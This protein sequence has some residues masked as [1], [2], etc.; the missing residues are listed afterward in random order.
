MKSKVCILIALTLLCIS[1]AMVNRASARASDSTRRELVES[2]Y[3]GTFTQQASDREQ[4][5]A[6]LRKRIMGQEKKPAGEVFPGLKNFRNIPAGQ[7]PLIMNAFSRALGVGCEHCHVSDKYES[8]DKPQK[9]IAREMMK[10]TGTIN[11]SLLS[12]IKNLKSTKPEI[13]CSTCHRGQVIPDTRLP[14]N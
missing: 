14:A 9:Q 3:A 2:S 10:M 12:N 7:L 11:E 8:E 5:L 4:A 1:A 13:S 6:A